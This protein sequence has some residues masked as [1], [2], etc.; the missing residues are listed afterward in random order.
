ML[1]NAVGAMMGWELK[2]AENVVAGEAVVEPDGFMWRV[3]STRR[4]G[5]SVVLGLAPVM[6]TILREQPHEARVGAAKLVRVAVS[7]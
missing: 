3:T 1:A 7:A 4:S 6:Q 5:R 2:L